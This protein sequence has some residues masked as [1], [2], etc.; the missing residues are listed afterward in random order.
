LRLGTVRRTMRRRR[1]W[2]LF[3]RCFGAGGRTSRGIF[4][5][6]RTHG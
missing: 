6:Y 5:G 2:L 1:R 4:V 3:G